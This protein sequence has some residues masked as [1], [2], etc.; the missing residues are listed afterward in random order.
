MKIDV[1]RKIP[2]YI[3]TLIIIHEEN[4]KISELEL[5]DVDTIEAIENFV[6]TED[7][8]F[9]SSS[10]RSFN[11]MI[12][13]KPQNVIVAGAGDK[14]K[15]DASILRKIFSLCWCEANRMKADQV[16]LMFG[17]EPT[18]PEMTL[19]HVLAETA[20][21]NAYRFHKYLSE[22][23]NYEIES[24]HLIFFAKTNRHLNSGILEGRIYAETTNLARDLVNEPPNVMNPESLADYAKKA[25]LQYGFPID[26]YSMDKLRRLKMD[27]L[28]SV[29][30]GSKTEPKLILM[31][32][33]GNPDKKHHTVALVGKGLTFDSGGYSL[34]P[35]PSMVSM[36]SDMSGAAA[37]IG[38]LAAIA[39]LKLKVNVLG[40]I[41]AAE[42]MIGSNAYRPGDIITSMAGKTIEVHNTDAEGRLTLIDAIHYALEKEKVDCV[43][44]IATLTGAA[45]AALGKDF[46]AVLSND[47]AWYE[48]L[49]KASEAC[50][51]KI[52]R[53][54]LHEDYKELL[55]SDVADLKNIGGP[56]A[57]CITAAL[58]IQEFVQNKPWIH[59]DIAG[60]ATRDKAAGGEIAGATGVGVRLLT[61]LIRNM[62]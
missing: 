23:K 3:E 16:Y 33:N 43:L 57:G 29:G 59:I 24:I 47:D 1:C 49:S 41:G 42:N 51:E 38:T 21:L 9:E 53:M 4:A 62:E 15:L 2:E 18:L 50:G 52:W 32:Y 46:S 60:T 54:P 6:D 34:K 22:H 14:T 13:K 12:G 17:F 44:D 39:T 36:K 45:V 26:I 20:I 30:K 27:A 48:M 5:L 10:I 61:N 11:R 19:G 28:L 40:V 55:K 58:F 56:L 7:Y 35:G 25:A 31:R 8:H 37:V